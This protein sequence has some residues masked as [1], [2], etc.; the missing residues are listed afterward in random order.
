T[1]NSQETTMTTTFAERVAKLGLG[2]HWLVEEIDALI[3][4]QDLD[5]LKEMLDMGFDQP[6]REAHVKA[7]FQDVTQGGDAESALLRRVHEFVFGNAELSADDR[8]LVESAFPLEV[9][10]VSAPDKRITQPWNLGKSDSP[11]IINLGTLTIEQGA[12]VTIENT[13]LNFNVDT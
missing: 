12:Y 7:L 3:T 8:K 2:D 13:L 5:H 10:I 4:V 1:N 11:Q 6:A 9:E